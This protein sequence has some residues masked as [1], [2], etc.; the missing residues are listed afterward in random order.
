MKCPLIRATIYTTFD[1]IESKSG[2][3]LREECAWWHEGLG[4]CS[5]YLIQEHLAIIFGTLIHIEDKISPGG[6]A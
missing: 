1:Q 6:K 2:E 3:C 4:E 5:V